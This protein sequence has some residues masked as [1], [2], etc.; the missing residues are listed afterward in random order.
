[1]RAGADDESVRPRY[2][3][4]GDAQGKQQQAPSQT[5]ILHHAF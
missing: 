1:V 2:S 4:I 5:M 3:G